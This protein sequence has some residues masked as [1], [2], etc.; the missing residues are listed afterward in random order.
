MLPYVISLSIAVVISFIIA[1]FSWNR[2]PATGAVPLAVLMLCVSEW[3]LMQLC[4]EISTTLPAKLF[5]TNFKFIGIVFVPIAWLVLSLRYTHRKKYISLRNILLL[6]I[7]PSLSLLVLYTN[8]YHELFMH[9]IRLIRRGDVMTMVS[10]EGIWFWLHTAY[11]YSLIALATVLLIL[12]CFKQAAVYRKQTL[13]LIIGAFIPFIGNFLSVFRVIHFTYEDITPL[14]LLL[15]GLLFFWALFR[16]KLLD[17]VPIARDVIIENMRDAIIVMDNRNR[18]IDINPAAAALLDSNSASVLGQPA[19]SVFTRWQ[20]LMD[21]YRDTMALQEKITISIH[22]TQRCLDVQILPVFD[23]RKV[24]LGRLLVLRDITDLQN[25]I[26]E[27]KISRGAAEAASKAKSQ[28]LATMSHEIRT[29]MNAVIGLS[30]LLAAT[31][32]DESQ[33]EYVQ[34]IQTSASSLMAIIN[35]I[36]DFSKIEAGKLSLDHTRFSLRELVAQ[37]VKPFSLEA[38]G[39]GLDLLT[40]IQE[41][42]P[43]IVGGDPARL[44]QILVNLI[45]N[46]L[47]FTAKGQIEII[48]EK[49]PGHTSPVNLR[50]SVLD[51]GIGIPPEKMSHLFERFHQLDNTT[52]RKYGGTGLGLSIVKSLV[53]LMGGTLDVKSKPGVGSRFSVT[54]PFSLHETGCE[55]GVEAAEA[56]T[57]ASAASS[58][59]VLL[60]EDNKTNQLLMTTLLKK[61]GYSTDIARNGAEALKMLEANKYDLILMDVQMPEMDGFEATG[62]IRR[63]ESGTGKHIPIIALTANAMSGDREQCLSASMDDYLSKPVNS[64]DLHKVLG[65]YLTA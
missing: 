52:T 41:D 2:K 10:G 42:I 40:T 26:E 23:A 17:L 62:E 25:A 6:C 63:L 15:T 20:D 12:E 3:T 27:L 4:I 7:I 37:T 57:A 49:L 31:D 48:V 9:S 21:K 13:I 24:I 30:G 36:L 22:G 46:A 18:I 34:L 5:F 47:K 54:L 35:D 44:K 59:R 8:Y 61:L 45:G 33:A 55:S 32:L 19:A 58:Y 56:H 53:E 38:A 51:T 60:A 16:H 14:T 64:R 11:S 39:K 43:S 29:P 28:F 1:L 65:K 50:F